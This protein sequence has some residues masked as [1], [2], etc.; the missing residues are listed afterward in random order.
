MLSELIDHAR[1]DVAKVSDPKARAL[2]ETTSE[3]LIAVRKAFEDYE[4]LN[5]PACR[6]RS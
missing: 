1:D 5:E 4:R 3:V 6:Q 2:C